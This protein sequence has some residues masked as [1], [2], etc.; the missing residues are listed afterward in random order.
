MLERRFAC[1]LARKRA[2][3]STVST[4]ALFQRW[5]SSLDHSRNFDGKVGI[6]RVCVLKEA[7]RTTIWLTEGKGMG[8]MW[9]STTGGT[10]TDML[11]LICRRSSRRWRSYRRRKRSCSGTV[12][13]LTLATTLRASPTWP[14]GE[15]DR[16]SRSSR[17][18]RNDQN[19]TWTIWSSLLPSKVESGRRGMGRSMGWFRAFVR[20]SQSMTAMHSRG[21]GRDLYLKRYNQVLRARGGGDFEVEHT[22]TTQRKKSESWRQQFKLT[23][24]CSTRYLFGGWTQMATRKIDSHEKTSRNAINATTRSMVKSDLT[25]MYT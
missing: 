16:M 7:Q 17:N 18:R 14:V 9:I 12:P 20:C 13:R 2:D 8:A 6:W 1:S 5:F 11:R 23:G 22:A 10:K 24:R 15:G 3:R 4:R 19:S 21:C 25:K